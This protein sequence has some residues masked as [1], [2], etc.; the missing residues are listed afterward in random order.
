MPTVTPFLWFDDQVEAAVERYRSLF[1]DVVVHEVRRQPDGSVFII[2][3]EVC[4]QRVQGMNGGPH[5]QLSPAFSFSVLCDE[6]AEVDRYWEGLLADGG[7]PSRCGWLVDPFGVS[8]QIVPREFTE[9]LASD[10]GEKVARMT[11][12]MLTMD[13]L[14]LDALRAAFDGTEG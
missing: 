6:Q 3:F 5:Y 9:L 2:D 1:P 10:E 7:E 8:W 13:K 11:E 4:G 12:V 14:E